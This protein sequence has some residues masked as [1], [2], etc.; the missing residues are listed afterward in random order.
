LSDVQ[1][2]ANG[3]GGDPSGEAPK[4]ASIDDVKALARRF[5][6]F[7]AESKKASGDIVAALSAKLE[8]LTASAALA[9]ASAPAADDKTGAHGPGQSIEDHP[10]VKG[11]LKRIAEVEGRAKTAEDTAAAEKARARDGDMRRRLA[12]ALAGHGI[13]GARAKHAVGFLVDAQKLVRLGE[14]NESIVFKDADS[15]DVDLATGLKAWIKTEDGKLYKPPSGA[16]GSGD[17]PFGN[18]PQKPG[19]PVSR[20]AVGAM[21]LTHLRGGGRPA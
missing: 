10:T 20:E 11:L 16:A 9:P 17:R 2:P 13:D 6:A 7:A 8:E 19:E 1:N 4:Y 12:D 5:D 18:V 14:D 3:Q 21:L 15:G